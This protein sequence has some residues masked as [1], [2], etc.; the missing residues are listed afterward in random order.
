MNKILRMAFVAA[1]IFV[2]ANTFA[3][4]AAEENVTFS[5]SKMIDNG[6]DKGQSLDGVDYSQKGVTMSFS[7]GDGETDPVYTEHTY[8]GGK[9]DNVLQLNVGNKLTFSSTT[10]TFTKVV[11][12]PVA[13]AKSPKSEKSGPNYEMSEGEYTGP[14]A[15]PKYTWTG[16]TSD[17]FLKNK[18]NKG[19]M[20]FSRVVV[21]CVDG[22]TGI[23]SVTTID[24]TDGK[25]Y[26]IDGQYVGKGKESVTKSG[27]YVVNGKKTIIRK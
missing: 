4:N 25:V 9:T 16:K 12:T 14:D 7:K 19:G 1:S 18:N 23:E 26:S 20:V 27:V 15:E 24:L 3:Q 2:S 13:K 6:W 8:S 11:F 22:Y 10:K 5:L 21:T 17:F